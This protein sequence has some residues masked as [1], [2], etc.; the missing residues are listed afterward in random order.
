VA[1]TRRYRPEQR[2]STR[3]LWVAVNRGEASGIDLVNGYDPMSTRRYFAFAQAVEGRKFWDGVYQPEHYPPL[4]R[5]AGVTHVLSQAGVPLGNNVAQLHVVAAAGEWKLWRHPEPWSRVY[6]SRKVV[7]LTE[8]AQLSLLNALATQPFAQSGLPVVAAP[9][10]LNDIA[11]TPLTQA[12]HVTSWRRGF[13]EMTTETTATAPSVLVQA[14]A[15]YPGWRAWVNGQ[16]ARVERV[17]FMFRGIRVPAGTASTQ[18]AYE[19]QTYR[20]AVFLTL[21]GLAM[22]AAWGCGWT[23][24]QRQP[25]RAGPR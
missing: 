19:P 8:A 1:L 3:L 15:W 25:S 10:V 24:G 2:W 9:T 23:W 5:V 6:L 22:V 12:D 20:F 17:N 11:A 16:P 4:L 7:P 13:N 21:C 18:V 14:E